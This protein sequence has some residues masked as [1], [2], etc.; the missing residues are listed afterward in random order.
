MHNLVKCSLVLFTIFGF[1]ETHALVRK[2]GTAR[3]GRAPLLERFSWKILDWNYPSE[4]SRQ[5]ALFTGD[6]QPKN[7][8]PVGIEIWRDKLFVTVPRWKNG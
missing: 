2:G 3:F 5:Q 6:Y 4:T 8:L 1:F 7:A